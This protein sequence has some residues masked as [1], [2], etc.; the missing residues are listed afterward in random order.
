[1]P[2]HVDRPELPS[3]S[4]IVPV[5]NEEAH[6]ENCLEAIVNQ[7][8]PRIVEILVAD[9]GS[10]DSTR[11]LATSVPK[12]RLL[13]NPLRLQAGGLNIALAE[14]TG[15]VTVRV[16]GHTLIPRDYVE[17][18]VSLLRVTRAAMV[19]GMMIPARRGGYVQRAVAVAMA[20]RLG[21]GPARF[22]VG[23]ASGW[24]D[25]VY[26]GCYWTD[27][28]RQ[29]GGYDARFVPNEDAEFARRMGRHGGVWF[30]PAIRATYSPRDSLQKVAGQFLRY[31]WARAATVRRH[32]ASISA[33][34]LAAPLLVLGLISSW[35]RWVAA[36]YATAVT[37]RAIAELPRDA[38]AAAG[39]LLVLPAMHLPWGVGFL[40]GLVRARRACPP[41][42][43]RPSGT[44]G[45]TMATRLHSPLR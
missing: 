36:C 2:Q 10:S 25:T 24:V 5:L 33:R 6:I 41:S 4:V 12:V 9:G 34:Q 21:A 13:K 43:S 40:A 37:T 30:D 35:R 26:L 42:L 19:G 20:S 45:M 39:L 1:M 23:G 11:Q 15:D 3:V 29:I 32:P 7:T 17:R 44:V 16:D 27:L 31:G 38:Q 28:A 8:Y 22:H 18:C 14:A